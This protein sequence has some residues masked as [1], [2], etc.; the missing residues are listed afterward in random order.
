MIG[1]LGS[2]TLE[3]ISILLIH[4]PEILV[5]THLLNAPHQEGASIDNIHP[6]L[7]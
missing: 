3:S 1:L 5:S 2:I 7:Q 4:K 6:L